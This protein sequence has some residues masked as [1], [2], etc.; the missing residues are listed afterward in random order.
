MGSVFSRR[1][2]WVIEYR[3]PYGMIRRESA[4]KRDVR[5]R[6]FGVRKTLEHE[7]S[8]ASKEIYDK[9]VRAVDN[10]GLRKLWQL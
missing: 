2:S 10:W 6:S 8:Q 9:L 7:T 4:G 5:G 3:K 1:D